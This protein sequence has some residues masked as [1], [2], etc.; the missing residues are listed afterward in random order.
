M[1]YQQKR[2]LINRLYY[3]LMVIHFYGLRKIWLFRYS[4]HTEKY[5]SIWKYA[6]AQYNMENG[7]IN[8]IEDASKIRMNDV[9]NFET[10]PLPTKLPMLD[11]MKL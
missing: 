2:L 4:R 1:N 11:Y 7:Y 5:Y 3:Y 6:I 9:K 8:R 10:D